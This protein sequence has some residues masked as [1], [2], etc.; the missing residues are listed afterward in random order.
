MPVLFRLCRPWTR[1]N[2]FGNTVMQSPTFLTA[3]PRKIPFAR[4][5]AAR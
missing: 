3:A 2:R 5:A 1:R 4:S